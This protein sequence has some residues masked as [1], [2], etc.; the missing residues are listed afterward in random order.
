MV[1]RSRR[2][3]IARN[4][5][6]DKE[7]KA[8]TDGKLRQKGFPRASGKKLAVVSRRRV[9]LGMKNSRSDGPWRPPGIPTYDS[10][11]Y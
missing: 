3:H 10:R 11:I 6:A 4:E 7:A 9:K 8:A 2:N 5:D 1:S